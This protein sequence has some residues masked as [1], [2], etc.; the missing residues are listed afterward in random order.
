MRAGIGGLDD[1]VNGACS[2]PV[3]FMLPASGLI[4]E[5]RRG[6]KRCG[7]CRESSTGGNFVPIPYVRR[8][9]LLVLAG[10][11]ALWGKS[12]RDDLRRLNL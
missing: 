9:A 1:G 11:Q 12:E 6:R 5:S 2:L 8:W 10:I 4:A 3:A 7:P